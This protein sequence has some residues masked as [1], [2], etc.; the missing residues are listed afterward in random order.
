[1]GKY[2][3]AGYRLRI[4][5]NI[6]EVTTYSDDPTIDI[7]PRHLALQRICYDAES[8]KKVIDEYMELEKVES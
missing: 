1:M 2:M 3:L 8:M 5:E 4:E 6:A 7:R